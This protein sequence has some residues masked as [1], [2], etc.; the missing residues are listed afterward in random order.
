MPVVPAPALVRLCLCL[1]GDDRDKVSSNTKVPRCTRAN[2]YQDR[3]YSRVGAWSGSRCGVPLGLGA[4][5]ASSTLPPRAPAEMRS[6]VTVS[7]RPSRRGCCSGRSVFVGLGPQPPAGLRS[8]GP[9]RPGR[10]DVPAGRLRL[11]HPGCQAPCGSRRWGTHHR[12]CCGQHSP[13]SSV[14]FPH[15]HMHTPNPKTH[16]CMHPG[17]PPTIV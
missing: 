12:R 2:D 5:Q 4:F 11:P 3:S 13:F 14:S 16:M 10:G 6:H 8:G 15:P 9:A 17:I 1:W 7:L